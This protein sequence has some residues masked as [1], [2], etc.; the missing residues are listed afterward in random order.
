MMREVEEAL[1]KEHHKQ[2]MRLL[3]DA[4]ARA[5]KDPIELDL[6]D[7]KGYEAEMRALFDVMDN[8]PKSGKISL[9]EVTAP[10]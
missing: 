2:R 1:F 7:A 10:L 5:A 4:G 3:L 6:Q 9:D 8:N